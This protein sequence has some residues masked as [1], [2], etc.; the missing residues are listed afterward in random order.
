M[1]SVRL[2][3]CIVF[4]LCSCWTDWESYRIRNRSVLLFALLGLAVN[5]LQSGTEGLLRSVGGFAV[6]LPLFALFAAR[7][8][9]AGD[10]KA[11]MTVGLILGWPLALRAVLYSLMCAG[12]LAAAV[13]VVRRNGR[14][15]M[16]R[17][18]LW[19]KNCWYSRGFISYGETE[20]SGGFRFSFGIL[21]G[22]LVLAAEE[23]LCTG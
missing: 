6:M 1:T 4:T 9:G 5:C 18:W 20:P 10:V 17:L 11:L 8:L 12:A 2:G 3:I 16:N 19:C 14:E 23:L 21:A 15:R 7:M 22:V 13:L